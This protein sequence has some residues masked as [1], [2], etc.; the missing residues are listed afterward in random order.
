ME[1]KRVQYISEF[2]IRK[3]IGQHDFSLIVRNLKK[4]TNFRV[5]ISSVVLVRIKYMKNSKILGSNSEILN[6]EFP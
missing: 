1:F 2:Q 5:G 6:C 3:Q 4:K